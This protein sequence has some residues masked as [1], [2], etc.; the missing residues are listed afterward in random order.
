M[1]HGCNVQRTR[2]RSVGMTSLKETFQSLASKSS[3]YLKVPMSKAFEVLPSF[4]SGGALLWP[5]GNWWCVVIAL[6]F[7]CDVWW[8]ISGDGSS[9]EMVIRWLEW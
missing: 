2:K 8:Y 7:R 4:G 5:R 6:W 9:V 3:L 1:L